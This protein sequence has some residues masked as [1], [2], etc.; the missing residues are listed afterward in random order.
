[1][2]P[3]AGKILVATLLTETLLVLLVLVSVWLVVERRGL[4]PLFRLREDVT[5]IQDHDLSPIAAGGAPGEVRPL[6]DALNG[7]FTPESALPLTAAS[8]LTP[9]TS[10]A[11]RLPACIRKLSWLCQD[12]SAIASVAHS[13][14]TGLQ[15]AS[16]SSMAPW[17]RAT[18]AAQQPAASRAEIDLNELARATTARSGSARR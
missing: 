3:A 10:Y 11:R 7:L 17:L 13:T 1:M 8:W 5:T 18:G 4:A 14:V 2:A 6:V 16:I 9:R 12:R 15:P